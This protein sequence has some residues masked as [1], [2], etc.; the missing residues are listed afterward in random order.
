M[1]CVI[2]RD[3]VPPFRFSFLANVQV[4]SC[5][6]LLVCCLKC[7]YNYFP[8][9]FLF[10]C[11]ICSVDP[12]VV[13]IVSGGC[14]QSSFACFLCKFRV[15]VSVRQ[16]YLQCWQVLFVL[17]FLTHIVCYCLL[18][19]VM[20]FASSLV[21]LFSGPLIIINIIDIITLYYEFF[22]CNTIVWSGSKFNAM[23][24]TVW[25]HILGTVLN[26]VLWFVP[27]SIISLPLWS[28][29]KYVTM[30]WGQLL[31]VTLSFGY[32][33]KCNNILA[34]HHCN[35]ISVTTT[36]SDTSAKCKTVVHDKICGTKCNKN[37][38]SYHGNGAKCVSR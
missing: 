28:S 4:F 25:M 29:T 6:M 9:R 23:V 8:F 5:E 32:G 27:A 22:T 33:T 3:S 35:N 24:C 31:F 7:P 18:W 10:P 37:D 16:R 21:F 2:W 14:N 17:L 20:S 34:R 30:F 38:G 36:D 15:V 1:F 19:D 13:C 26:L 11:Y 12:R